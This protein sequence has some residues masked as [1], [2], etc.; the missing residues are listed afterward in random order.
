MYMGS[1]LAKAAALFLI[2]ALLLAR[3]E[4]IAASLAIVPVSYKSYSV[5]MAPFAVLAAALRIYYSINPLLPN[6]PIR[7]V[8]PDAMFM[9][10]AI[11]IFSVLFVAPVAEEL[12]FRGYL[13]GAFAKPLGAYPAIWL[14]SALFAMVHMPQLKCEIL[15]TFIIFAL[16]FVFSVLRYRTRSVLAPILFHAIYNAVYVSVGAINYFLVGY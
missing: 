9:G 12:I 8:F 5:Y 14:V 7:F 4:N 11:I 15:P 16:G 3:R 6:L 2:F 10:N 1:L 13:Y